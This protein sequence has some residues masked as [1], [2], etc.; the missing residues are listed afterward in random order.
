MDLFNQ[1]F[2]VWR[3]FIPKTIQNK[4]EGFICFSMK[5]FLRNV[6]RISL[7]LVQLKI[8]N[9]RE[10]FSW[11]TENC[12]QRDRKWLTH[13][14]SVNYFVEQ[15]YAFF[16]PPLPHLCIATTIS[17]PPHCDYHV[18]VHLPSLTLLPLP[19]LFIPHS[20]MLLPLP[21]PNHNHRCIPTFRFW[22]RDF[23]YN[24]TLDNYF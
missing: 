7:C 20:S 10:S 18:Q 6:F 5:Y 11:S 1:Y 12:N 19:P 24:Q 3:V 13:C 4:Y 17:F 14:W 23:W 22:N 2:E 15:R 8:I 9:W 21:P 16:P